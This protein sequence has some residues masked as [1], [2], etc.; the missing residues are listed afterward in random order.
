M[1]DRR[2]LVVVGNG[3]V[4]HKLLETARRP[5]AAATEPW[6]IVTF[7]EEPRPAY[8]RVGLSSFFTG[9][10]ADDLSLVERRLLRAPRHHRAPRRPGRRRSTARPAR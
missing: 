5:A 10:T 2:R 9:S 1:T 8:D 4:G 6:Q 7:C 3:M